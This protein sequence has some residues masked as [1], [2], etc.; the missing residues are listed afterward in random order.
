VLE[1]KINTITKNDNLNFLFGYQFNET[2]MLNQTTVSAHFS[3]V[4]KKDVVV[5]ALFSEI[6]YNKNNTYLEL[7]CV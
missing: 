7:D 5:N 4:P 2:G 6:E 3:P 1:T